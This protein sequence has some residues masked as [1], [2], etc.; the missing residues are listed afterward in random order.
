MQ[1]CQ[2]ITYSNIFSLATEQSTNYDRGDVSTYI[3]DTPVIYCKAVQYLTYN[4]IRIRRDADI[5]PKK[6]R[7]LRN[8]KNMHC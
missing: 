4:V 3:V 8:K 6:R 5:Y 7:R 2:V 1:C